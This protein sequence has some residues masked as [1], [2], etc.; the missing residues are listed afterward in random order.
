[1]LT[2]YFHSLSV[3]H[4]EPLVVPHPFYPTHTARNAS[5]AD[6]KTTAPCFSQA[7]SVQRTTAWHF[8]SLIYFF[9][10]LAVLTLSSFAA[11]LVGYCSIRE[12]DQIVTGILLY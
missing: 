2:P 3:T 7:A 4:L 5:F 8:L 11:G 12:P 9:V 6:V 1:M 10:E